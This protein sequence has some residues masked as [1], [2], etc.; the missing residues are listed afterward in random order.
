MQQYHREI[1]DTIDC[2][3]KRSTN[4]C[5]CQVPV[6]ITQG[7][8]IFW[9]GLNGMPCSHPSLLSPSKL[10]SII[11]WLYVLYQQTWQTGCNHLQLFALFLSPIKKYLYDSG[12]QISTECANMGK[13]LWQWRRPGEILTGAIN[14]SRGVLHGRYKK[15]LL[16]CMAKIR[17]FRAT[18]V[19]FRRLI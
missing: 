10:F 4:D 6:Q 19:I 14:H 3:S 5:V 7:F 11:F 17:Y 12:V 8:D 18:G 15:S 13:W 16:F 9:W 1:S 2:Q